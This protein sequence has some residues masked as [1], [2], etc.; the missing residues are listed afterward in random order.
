M[1]MRLFR[2]LI[3]EVQRGKFYLPAA[4]ELF[5]KLHGA[6]WVCDPIDAVWEF[7]Q[8][9]FAFESSNVYYFV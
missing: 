8:I 2:E 9:V 5:L 7:W 4:K 6:K 3:K 1:G